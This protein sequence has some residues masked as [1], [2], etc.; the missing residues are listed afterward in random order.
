MTAFYPVLGAL[1]EPYS[2]LLTT[3]GVTDI[4]EVQTTEILTLIGCII[5]NQGAG[6]N[7]VSVWWT[8]GTD[9]FL[10]YTGS[11]PATSTEKIAIDVPVRLFGR[12]GTRKI[13]AQAQTADEV[14]VTLVVTSTNEAA[15][16]R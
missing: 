5:A 1:E 14:T 8:K 13:K 16:A 2:T 10:I 12:L 7:L 9:D 4:H 6:A 3:T 11:V 15:T